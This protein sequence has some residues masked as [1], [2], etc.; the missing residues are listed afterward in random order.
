MEQ[1][2]QLAGRIRVFFWHS[3]GARA[4]IF[5]Q[6]CVIELPVVQTLQKGVK[7]WKLNQESQFPVGIQTLK[8]LITVQAVWWHFYSQCATVR[9][10]S[11]SCLSTDGRFLSIFV[12][13]FYRATAW[14]TKMEMI[15]CEVLPPWPS[16]YRDG[17]S[18]DRCC[19][20]SILR[21]WE[22]AACSSF[23]SQIGLGLE[24]VVLFLL[25]RQSEST[26][27]CIW[28]EELLFTLFLLLLLQNF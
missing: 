7:K 2:D 22:A 8:L 25:S 9:T 13:R 4:H 10:A 20:V 19:F 15:C 17:R 18:A 24:S 14:K 11:A 23:F 1:G 21:P 26:A 3:S 16:Y 5:I 12:F 6:F 28:Q 27:S